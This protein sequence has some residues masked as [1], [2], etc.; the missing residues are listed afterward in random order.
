MTRISSIENEETI[1]GMNTTAIGAD[2]EKRVFNYLS[3]L[4]DKDE[5]PQANKK[6]SKIFFHKS[7]QTDTSREIDFDISIETYNPLS[8]D[9]AWTSLIVVECKNY[10]NKVDISDLDEFQTKLKKVSDSGIKGIMATTSGFTRAEIETA[11]KEHIALV[12]FN[13]EQP[14]WIVS[15]DINTKPEHMMPR[16]CGYDEVGS[17]PIVYNDGGFTSIIDLLK[18]FEVSINESAILNVPYLSKET[19]ADFVDNLFVK[20]PCTTKD[21]AGEI[22]YKAFPDIKINFQQMTEGHLGY[23]SFID[24][25]IMLSEVLVKD[26]HRRNFTIA[27]EL[28]HLFLHKD[29]LKGQMN[30]HTEYDERVTAALPDQI[31]KRIE[32]QA[33]L[34]AS[35]ILLPKNKFYSELNELCNNLRIRRRLYLD[36]QPCNISL[37]TT[38]LRSISATFNVSR[39][40]V[41]MRLLNDGLLVLGKG[42]PQRI[43]YI[44]RDNSQILPNQL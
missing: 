25:V 29:L 32:I 44:F 26:E 10:K 30:K 27:H 8:K 17:V 7:Y 13:E 6:Y 15:R 16:L 18:R 34:F 28:G 22:L 41:K 11:Q 24:D 12:V 36:N 1:I 5:L 20:Y 42:I 43:D 37:V 40:M 35:Y 33:N 19:I 3:G 31:I 38:V 2:F 23:I 21:Y 9:D 39:E 14:E 4:L